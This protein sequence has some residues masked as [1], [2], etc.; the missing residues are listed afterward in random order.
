MEQSA[1]NKNW[2]LRW[3]KLSAL[4]W[5]SL[6]SYALQNIAFIEIMIEKFIPS[7]QRNIR[8]SK[9][10]LFFTCVKGNELKNVFT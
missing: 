3:S 8:S 4:L 9:Y 7:E 10:H 6:I 2:L 1:R 5:R